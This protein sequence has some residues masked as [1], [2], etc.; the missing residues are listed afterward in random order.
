MCVPAIAS[1]A[2]LATG[3]TAATAAGATAGA[4]TIGSTLAG[5]G[6]ITSLGASIYSGITGRQ[7]ARANA[8]AV[9]DRAATEA[10]LTA[11]QDQRETEAFRSQIRQ[12]TAELAARGVSLD[13]PTAVL[14]GQTAGQEL[15]FQSQAI[16]SAGAATQQ[17]LTAQERL[18]VAQ[19]NQALLSGVLSGAGTFLTAAPK[20]WPELLA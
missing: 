5:L 1:L 9:R 16:R 2:T 11:T 13:S 17:E 20:V 12:Q 8:K 7:T 10:A 15:S 6:A 4:A 3:A 18:Y 14:L 19:G